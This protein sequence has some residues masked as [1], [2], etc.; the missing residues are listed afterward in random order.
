MPRL[1]A[2]PPGTAGLQ[3]SL[4]DQP[5]PG[6]NL[7]EFTV[8]EIAKL[9]KKT[10]EDTFGQVRVRGEI[11]GLK[12]APSG[13]I[14]F[15]LKDAEATLASICWRGQAGQLG[16]KLEI[17]MEVICTGKLTTYPARSNYQ[18]IIDQAA[19]AGMGALLKLLEDRKKKLAA[20]GLFDPSRKQELPFLPEVIGVVTSPTGA[21]IRDILHRLRDRFPRHVLLWP[22]LVQGDGAQEQIDAA[23]VGF[24]AIAPGGAIPRP[25]LLIV[26][27]GGGS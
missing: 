10:M 23:I 22:V 4:L 11:S 13:H 17:G 8:S 5:R 9:V 24:N 26:A 20:E 12:V 2:Q 19:L 25:D 6:S 7:P 16:I 18:L 1:S 27:R 14:Y 21:V 15:D 3:G